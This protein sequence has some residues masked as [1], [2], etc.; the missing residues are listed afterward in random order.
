[1][2]THTPSHV[3]HLRT[4]IQHIHAHYAIQERE[5]DTH[6]ELTVTRHTSV[7]AH[8]AAYSHANAAAYSHAHA[9]NTFYR[10]SLN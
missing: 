4:H 6:R 2:A 8:G 9:A 7:H 3:T 10:E 1:M 5:R